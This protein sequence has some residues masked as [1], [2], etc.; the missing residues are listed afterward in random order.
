M[1]GDNNQ[2]KMVM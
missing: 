2:K 1:M